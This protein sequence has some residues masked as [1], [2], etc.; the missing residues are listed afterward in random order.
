MQN[1]CLAGP[2]T[3]GNYEEVWVTDTHATISRDH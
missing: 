1:G 2:R 3:A